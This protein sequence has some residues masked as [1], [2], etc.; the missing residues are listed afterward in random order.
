MGRRSWRIAYVRLLSQANLTIE[1]AFQEFYRILLGGLLTD[2]AASHTAKSG[3]RA[4]R[5]GVR[6]VAEKK[7]TDYDEVGTMLMAA[8]N[9]E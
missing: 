9:R 8:W 4:V 1:D 2:S 7:D 3:K 6:R 5:T